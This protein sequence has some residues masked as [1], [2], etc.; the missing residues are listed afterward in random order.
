MTHLRRWLHAPAEWGNIFS[1]K[2]P[3]EDSFFLMSLSLV[4]DAVGGSGMY[5][6]IYVVVVL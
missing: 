1:V 4:E 6:H 5:V 2:L 3:E